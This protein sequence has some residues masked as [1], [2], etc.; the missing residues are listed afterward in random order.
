MGGDSSPPRRPTRSLSRP[1]AE[2]ASDVWS[3]GRRGVRPCLSVLSHRVEPGDTEPKLQRR[4]RASAVSRARE[5]RD[6][7]ARSKD[8]DWRARG[9]ARWQPPARMSSLDCSRRRSRT[10]SASSRPLAASV[11]DI[12]DDLCQHRG[13]PS[14][15]A[16]RVAADPEVAQPARSA[17]APGSAPPRPSPHPSRAPRARRLDPVGKIG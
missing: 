8:H 3:R 16:D 17:A 5:Q 2:A 14:A 13:C 7:R 15:I 12:V 9:A 1:G 10:S 6:W 4:A 11:S